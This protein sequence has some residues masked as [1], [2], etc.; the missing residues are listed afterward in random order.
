MSSATTNVLAP[1]NR[2]DDAHPSEPRKHDTGAR[3][4]PHPEYHREGQSMAAYFALVDNEW[5]LRMMVHKIADSRI[6]RFI[7]PLL[8]PEARDGQGTMASSPRSQSTL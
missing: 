6:L 1:P 2:I 7:R 5:V 4:S 8:E 3:S